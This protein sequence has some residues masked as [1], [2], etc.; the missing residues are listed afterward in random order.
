M[1]KLPDEAIRFFEK[2]GFVIISTLNDSGNIHTSAKGIVGIKKEGKIYI[3]D[4][5]RA[6]TYNNLKNNSAAT[7]T[8][9]EDH[10]FLGYS[11]EGKAVI[12]EHGQVKDQA[13]LD[14]EERVIQRISKRMMKNIRGQKSAGHHPEALFPSPQY[15]IEFDVEKIV[16]LAPANLKKSPLEE[17]KHQS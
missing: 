13:V 7:L 6:K 17:E 4:L 15:L 3:I 10:N 8:A 1:R 11:L 16:D 12:V 14:W 2:Q 9:A 5:Y